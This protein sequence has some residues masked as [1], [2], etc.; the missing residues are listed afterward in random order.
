[1]IF[2]FF[3]SN[4]LAWETRAVSARIETRTVDNIVAPVGCYTKILS[5]VGGAVQDSMKE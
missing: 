4:S 5:V 2:G 1:M 3:E